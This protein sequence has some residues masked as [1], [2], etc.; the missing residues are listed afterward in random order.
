MIKIISF[1]INSRFI[2]KIPEIIFFRKKIFLLLLAVSLPF[3]LY[4]FFDFIKYMGITKSSHEYLKAKDYNNAIK[5]YDLYIRKNPG[6]PQ[7][8]YNRGSVYYNLKDYDRAIENVSQ[9]I[10][11]N[12]GN[13]DFYIS[14][15][16]I[17]LQKKDF[18][19]AI[20]D[21]TRAIKLAPNNAMAYYNRGRAYYHSGKLDD[22]LKDFEKA[23]SMGV[24]QAKSLIKEIK[25]RECKQPYLK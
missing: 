5:A 23:Y 14:R 13:A 19:S 15:G 18:E 1:I 12:P 21:N 25:K 22:A 16:S 7:G 3:I 17:W 9:A 24:V 8:Y 6:D 2:K 4:Y 10:K 20:M 11:M